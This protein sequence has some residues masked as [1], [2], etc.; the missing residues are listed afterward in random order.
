ML[1]WALQRLRF[2]MAFCLVYE[3]AHFH[4]SFRLRRDLPARGG[5]SVQCLHHQYKR[6]ARSLPPQWQ[7]WRWNGNG[8]RFSGIVGSK[9]RAHRKLP[10]HLLFWTVGAYLL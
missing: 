3:F 6:F 10:A 9:H 7:D 8:L 5:C 4:A 2:T 1:F